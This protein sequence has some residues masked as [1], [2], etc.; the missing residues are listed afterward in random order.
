[1]L[2]SDRS[3]DSRR[4]NDPGEV[5]AIREYV[6]GDP[7]RNIH[8]K[9]SEKTDKLLVKGARQ[10]YHGSVPRYTGYCDTR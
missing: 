5:R 4:G 9:L 10:P 3:A 8:W 1:M 6:P 7:V 2:E